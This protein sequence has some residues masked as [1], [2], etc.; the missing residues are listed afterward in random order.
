MKKEEIF[1]IIFVS[2]S[3]IALCLSILALVK[4]IVFEEP[5]LE[6]E[7][8]TTNKFESFGE[9]IKKNMTSNTKC[10]VNGEVVNCSEI[11]DAGG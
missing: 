9:N 4:L 3:L 11:I 10:L 5:L 6:T 1:Q 7:I 2:L 8:T